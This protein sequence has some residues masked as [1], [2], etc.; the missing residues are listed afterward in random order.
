MYE[1]T[2]NNDVTL[3]GGE[4]PLLAGWCQVVRQLATVWIGIS[5]GG[6]QW[7]A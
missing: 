4:N 7:A 5:N 2:M 1:Q 3:T 6:L